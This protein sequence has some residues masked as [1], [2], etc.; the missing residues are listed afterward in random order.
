VTARRL[1][2]VV[3]VHGGPSLRDS[4]GFDHFG[5]LFVDR[6]CAFLRVDF[7]GSRGSSRPW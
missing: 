1:P 3:W 2:L 4:W 5:R 7:R 6:G